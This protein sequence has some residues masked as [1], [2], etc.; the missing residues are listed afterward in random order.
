MEAPPNL[1]PATKNP[2]EETYKKATENNE[3]YS[4]NLKIAEKD[5]IYISITFDGDKKL[6][7]DIKSYEDIKKKQAY[8]EDYSL[9]EIY[10]ELKD[11]IS[12][13]NFELNRNHEQILFN[14]VL[15]S[16]KK[17]TLD[18]VLEIKKAEN[19]IINNALFQQIIKQ[20]DDIIKKQD[21]IIKQKDEIIKEK[22][23]IIKSLEEIIKK[24]NYVDDTK[25]EKTNSKEKKED[26]TQTGKDNKDYNEIFKDF[27]IINHT[28]KNKLTNHGE[29]GINTILQLQDGRLAS[30]GDDGSIIIYNKQTF[31]PELTIKKHKDS[32]YDI[33]QLKNGNLLSCSRNDKTMNEYKLNENNTYQVLSTVNV[34]QDNYPRQIVELENNEIGLVAYNHI[35]FYLNINNKLDEDFK[36]KS[37]DNQIGVFCEMLPVK[38]GELVIAGAKDK[39]QF[40]E[41]NTRKL[42]EII[43]INR[44]IHWTPN[45][46]LC[47]MNERCL[48]VGGANKITIIDVYNKNIISEVEENGVNRCLYKLNDNILLTGKNNGDITQWR[49]N[50]NNLTFVNKKEKAHQNY[51]NEIIRF[52]NSIIS[53]SYDH[54]IKIW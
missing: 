33:I 1:K 29:K 5:S 44:D 8:F 39:I 40:F 48:C 14:I 19:D 6:Y 46:L 21:E 24:N 17:K 2:R 49:I 16:K 3:N 41:L 38:P 36:I 28:P 51:I 35:I 43:N 34:G 18:F 23:N 50:G 12:K 4:L 53:C 47:M 15:P 22:I 37:D 13:N 27:N 25:I 10:D 11:L 31:V 54:S 45:N 20:K 32:I 42:K 26:K 30:G 7:E 52:N 9:E